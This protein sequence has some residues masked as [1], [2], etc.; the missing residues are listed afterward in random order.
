M[1]E[2]NYQWLLF[3]QGQ[4]FTRSQRKDEILPFMASLTLALSQGEKEKKRKG[5]HPIGAY[6]RRKSL[7]IRTSAFFERPFFS[8]AFRKEQTPPKTYMSHPESAHFLS[9]MPGR[10]SIRLAEVINPRI[11]SPSGRGLG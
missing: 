7:Q 6:L 4:L 5:V 2:V 3:Y 9:S 10:S 11:P 8:F 1:N